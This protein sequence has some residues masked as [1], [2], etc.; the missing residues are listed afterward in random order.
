[1]NKFFVEKEIEEIPQILR[2]RRKISLKKISS[3]L[4]GPI[5]ICGVSSSIDL[6][7]WGI[8]EMADKLGLNI[9]VRY[10]NEVQ[11]NF[12][13][14][15]VIALSASGETE[16]TVDALKKAR[17]KIKIA[18]TGN[19]NSALAKYATHIIPMVCGEYFSDSATKSVVEQAYIVKQLISERFGQYVPITEKEINQ[20]KQ[21]LK[22][23]FPKEITDVFRRTNRVV[24]IGQRGFAEEVET[25]FQ[26]VARIQAEGIS[27]PLIF[28]STIEI[29][30]QGD[31]VL[32]VDPE[33]MVGYESTLAKASRSRDIFYLNQ[34][35]IKGEGSYKTIIRYAG[36]IKL[37]IDIG[38][39]KNVDI[40]HPEI[41]TR[42]TR[43]FTSPLFTKVKQ[44]VAIGGGSGIPS[45]I[46]AFK[47]LGHNVTGIT[48][49]VDSGGS[50]G[51]L[52]RDYNVL[53][54]GDIRRIIAGLSDHLRGTEM[55]NYRFKGGSLDG[56]TL[57]N[58][59]IAAME[60]IE[61][62]KEGKEDI[63][64]M[65]RAKGKALPAT[66]DNCQIYGELENGQ[67]LK[68]ED[69]IDIPLRNPFLK[70]KKVWLDPKGKLNPEAQKAILKADILTIGP[71]DL[72]STLMPSL[73]MKGM[74]EVIKKSKAKKIYI[75]NAMT[76]LGETT[77]YTV[78]D[79]VNEI[80]KYLGK[81]I[82][83]FALYNQ[84][85][86]SR[87]RILEFQK[88]ESFVFDYVKFNRQK[89]SKIK[90]PKIIGIDLL[91]SSVGPIIHDPD[92]LAKIILSLV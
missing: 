84:R 92:V 32:V 78:S 86:P 75:C 50:A 4:E 41:L 71:G 42:T 88:E 83:D 87:E 72:Y 60:K 13:A 20:L 33:R 80:E 22:L 74:P 48:S 1:M 56:H 43:G 53:P 26:E 64:K 51:K 36:L 14:D 35:K 40:D 6:P 67:I 81:N 9:K 52:R 11:D 24:I 69:E 21:N 16:E 90:K 76:K 73:L 5:L 27:G 34:L 15:V 23:E 68:G 58:I 2:R 12:P 46:R 47:K 57:G 39:S 30:N 10:S 29:L 17:A 54:P 19:K 55:M 66:L 91:T 79:F 62:F 45:L 65:L 7:G 63:E 44:V 25:K 3:L 38:K 49:M 18:I 59:L 77:T 61:G 82:L 85:I 89:L 28:Y 8:E 70:I 37:I 31:I